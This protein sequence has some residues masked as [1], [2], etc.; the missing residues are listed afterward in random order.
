MGILAENSHNW[1]VVYFAVV[2]LG[3]V[4]V[5]I[6]PDASEADVHQILHEMKIKVLFT[7]QRQIEKIYE[8]KRNQLTR[9]ITLDDYN[10]L[11]GVVETNTFSEMLARAME[12]HHQEEGAGTSFPDVDEDDPASV[13][14][15]SGTSGY[16]R[17]VVL[18]HKNLTA[19]VYSAAE[20][21]DFEPGAGFLSILPL[22]NTY[23]FTCGFL[24]PLLKGGRIIYAGKTPTPVILQKL[25]RKERPFAIFVVPLIVEKIY[26]KRIVPRIE[27]SKPFSLA[28]RT[29]IGR[30]LIHKKLGAELM[31]FF[32]GDLQV[33]GIGGV[34]LNREVE[35]FLAEA[36]FPYL[37]GYGLTE[38]SPLISGGPVGDDTI[39]MGSCGKPMANVEVRIVPENRDDERGEIQVRGPN[40]MQGYYRDDQATRKVLAADGWLST[41]DLGMI[42]GAGNLHVH[43]RVE[44]LIELEDGT[45]ISPESIEQRINS[46]PWVVESLVVESH[47]QLDGW[48]Y[49]DYEMIDEKTVGQTRSMRHEYIKTL[50]KNLCADLNEGI[51]ENK[52]LVHVFERR[53]PF[54]KTATHKIKRYLYTS[55]TMSG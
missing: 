15:T 10:C 36:G 55:Q 13:I 6:L 26:K 19:N 32:G 30:R 45:T 39:V 5:P 50:L 37:V 27:N 44:N 2:R 4:A 21:I 48:V 25:C 47:G 14:Y 20:H 41:G 1:G 51:P 54:M 17:A 24:L 29:K 34:R 43:G 33:L 18:S 52:R 28:C 40:V 23:E 38:T 35:C 53:E 46:F 16:P 49:P 11:L 3:A 8:L 7:T 31:D 12:D 42:D 22:A 9:I